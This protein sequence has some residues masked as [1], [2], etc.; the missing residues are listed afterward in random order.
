MCRRSVNLWS[1]VD[2]TSSYGQNWL[3]IRSLRWISPLNLVKFSRIRKLFFYLH[4]ADWTCAGVSFT[5]PLL[6][7]RYNFVRM[8]ATK[9]FIKTIFVENCMLSTCFE[10]TFFSILHISRENRKKSDS[11]FTFRPP[12]QGGSRGGGTGLFLI[13]LG[14]MRINLLFP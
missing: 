9:I 8:I 2:S 14:V 6:S 7:E 10:V 13:T 4:S 3:H 5:F 1:A 12:P 11:V